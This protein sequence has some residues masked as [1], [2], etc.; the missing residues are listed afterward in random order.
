WLKQLNMLIGYASFYNP[1]RLLGVLL[2]KKTKV[3]HKAAGMQ[4]VGMLGLAQTI[5]RTFVWAVRLAMGKVERL[6]RPP[7]SAIP[8]RAVDGTK[9][10]HGTCDAPVTPVRRSRAVSL[11]VAS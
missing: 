7:S 9:A 1:V 3:S 6:T 10:S 11:P 4:V 2:G 5:R 8:M